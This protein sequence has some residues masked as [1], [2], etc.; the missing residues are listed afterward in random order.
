MP[1]HS[2]YAY[3]LPVIAGAG[4]LIAVIVGGIMVIIT[5]IWIHVIKIKKAL[6]KDKADPSSDKG[7][8]TNDPEN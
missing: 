8:N 5:F 4:W 2:A 3:L 6:I 7:D 1:F